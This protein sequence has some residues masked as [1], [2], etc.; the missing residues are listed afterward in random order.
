[1]LI[2]NT[3]NTSS[4]SLS[5]TTNKVHEKQTAAEI[6]VHPFI[7]F[8]DPPLSVLSFNRAKSGGS[9]PSTT[10]LAVGKALVEKSKKGNNF[11]CEVNKFNFRIFFAY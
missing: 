3:N 9:V 1:M 10:V 4:S 11:L 8:I 5:S 6:G 7:G 2:N